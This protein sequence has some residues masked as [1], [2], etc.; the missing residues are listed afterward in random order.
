MINRID[1]KFRELRKN[2]KKALIVYIMSGLPDMELTQELVL[3]LDNSG[4]DLIELGVPF[5]DPVADGPVIQEAGVRVLKKG[6]NLNEIF[7][8]V[9]RIRK[10]T[11]IPLV[12]MLYYNLILHFGEERFVKIATACGVDGIIVPD[13]PAEE[14][15]L[16][17][18]FCRKRNLSTI[19][20]VTP[21]SS[22]ERLKQSSRLSSGFIYYISRTGVTGANTQLSA[23]LGSAVKRIA[24]FTKKPVCIGFGINNP[25]QVKSINKIC[26]GAII[27]SAVVKI[28]LE[29]NKRG[30]IVK[31]VCKF[32]RSLNV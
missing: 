32:V 16:L 8:L 25:K 9:K 15:G 11:Q 7:R 5:S 30:D 23:G 2:R 24:K 12:L 18:K 27:G 4:V 17:I 31:K 26:D 22:L 1:K 3:K 19:F 21:T 28:M 14:A 6:I 13:L 29:N 20:F 10:K